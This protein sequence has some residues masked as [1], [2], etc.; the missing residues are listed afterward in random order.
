MAHGAWSQVEGETENEV[1]GRCSN[2]SFARLRART[3]QKFPVAML[4]SLAST[5]FSGTST[6]YGS[7]MTPARSA[8]GTV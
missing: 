2:Q 3:M 5:Y 4:A 7:R 1:R 8:C 6:L